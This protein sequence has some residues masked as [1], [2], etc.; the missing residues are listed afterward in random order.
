MDRHRGA[1]PTELLGDIAHR[2]CADV[3]RDQLVDAVVASDIDRLGRH[4]LGLLRV[5]D[6]LHEA[7]VEVHTMCGGNDRQPPTSTSGSAE[8]V[9]DVVCV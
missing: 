4:R 3:H 1:V 6:T 2:L 5:F 7:G 9:V 8:G